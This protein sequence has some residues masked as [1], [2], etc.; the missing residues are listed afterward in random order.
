[1]PAA[2]CPSQGSGAVSGHLKPAF[3]SKSISILH[4]MRLPLKRFF[5]YDALREES[6]AR[7]LF[8]AAHN[9]GKRE[10]HLSRSRFPLFLF[11]FP[12]KDS[13]NAIPYSQ[14]CPGW[15][16][17]SRAIPMHTA[18]TGAACFIVRDPPAEAD[19]FLR[20][21]F[22]RKSGCRSSWHNFPSSRKRNR[23]TSISR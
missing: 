3:Y 7:V 5:P 12:L 1:M 17:E 16:L 6:K 11:I 18:C 21:I 15:F 22:R 9:S 8:L 19:P 13:C 4:A 2:P 10:R 14:G 23:R 20:Y